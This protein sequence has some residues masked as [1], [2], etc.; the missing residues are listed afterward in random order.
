LLASRSGEYILDLGC[1]TG[2][3]TQEIASS[4]A[5][6]KGIDLSQALIDRA[7]NHYP[8]LQFSVEDAKSFRCDRSFD[9]LGLYY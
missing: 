9:A 2:Q 4:G 6:V 8:H 1:G 3:L 5:E 7:R